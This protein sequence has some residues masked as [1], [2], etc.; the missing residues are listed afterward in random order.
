M[1][2]IGLKAPEFTL[3]D[4]NGNMVSLSDFAGKKVVLWFFPKA[5]TPG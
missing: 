5:S 3:P 1:L 4:I 2:E